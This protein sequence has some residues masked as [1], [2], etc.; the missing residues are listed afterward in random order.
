[1]SGRRTGIDEAVVGWVVNVLIVGSHEADVAISPAVST[2][3]LSWLCDQSCGRGSGML[4]SEISR[5]HEL[6]Q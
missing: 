2:M 4:A 5:T 3:L 1:M 6:I